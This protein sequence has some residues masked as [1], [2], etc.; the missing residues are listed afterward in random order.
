MLLRWDDSAA[1]CR[2]ICALDSF[3]VFARLA[4]FIRMS[5]ECLRMNYLLAQ[6]FWYREPQ[7]EDNLR[8]RFSEPW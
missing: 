3:P 8:L 1:D 6:R 7:L 5:R 4:R 2:C